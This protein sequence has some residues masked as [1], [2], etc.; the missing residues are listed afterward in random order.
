MGIID[1]IKAYNQAR[2]Y[3]I[4]KYQRGGTVT[5]YQQGKTFTEGGEEYNVTHTSLGKQG[6]RSGTFTYGA[7]Q[8]PTQGMGDPGFDQK[9]YDRAVKAAQDNPGVVFIGPDGIPR[10]KDPVTGMT[11]GLAQKFEGSKSGPQ[12]VPFKLDT[13][14]IGLPEMSK[15]NIPV[16]GSGGYNQMYQDE[17]G[18][19]YTP[20]QMVER[21]KAGTLPVQDF[22]SMLFKGDSKNV[23]LASRYK[24]GP[25]SNNAR[26]IPYGDVRNYALD[27]IQRNL[28]NEEKGY[29]TQSSR[30]LKRTQS[31]KGTGAYNM[32]TATPDPSKTKGYGQQQ[33][34]K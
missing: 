22:K 24:Q 7:R 19:M 27:Q 12:A 3:M 31:F 28:K 20:R 25:D 32:S 2:N 8:S 4:R 33:R 30:H 29:A 6:D 18:N 21:A 14:E 15:K 34:S 26:T 10:A 13:P 11:F 17:E 5:K 16:G 9:A 23:A 1:K